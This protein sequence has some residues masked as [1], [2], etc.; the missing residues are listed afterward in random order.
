MAEEDSCFFVWQILRKHE[1]GFYPLPEP[2]E[3]EEEEIESDT[4]KVLDLMAMPGFVYHEKWI[5]EKMQ[6]SGFGISETK[7]I[8]DHMEKKGI[9]SYEK[10]SKGYRLT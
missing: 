2:L 4:E 10:D 1:I 9:I 5:V 8:L 6:T 3:K 7:K